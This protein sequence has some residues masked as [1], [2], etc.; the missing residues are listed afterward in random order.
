MKW[1]R[2]KALVPLAVVLA[3]LVGVTLLFADRAVE[4]GVEGAGTHLVGARVDLDAA[5]LHVRD[6]SLA[7]R[8]LAV[9]NP[10]KPM[11]NLFEAAEIQMDLSVFPMLEQKLLLDTVAVRGLRFNTPRATSGAIDRPSE[12]AQVARRSVTEWLGGVKVPPLELSTLTKAVNVAGIS[13]ESLATLREARHAVAY[14]DTAKAKLLADLQ[15]LD[16]RPTIDS[17]QVLAERLKDAN[18]RTLGIG[19]TRQAVSDV[20]RTVAELRRLDDRLRAF[21]SE[22]RTNIGG[23][24]ARLNAIPAA[25]E[26]D[27]AYAKGLLRLPSF[28][29]PSLGPQLFSEVVATQVAEILYWAQMVERYI[30]PGIKRQLEPGPRRMRASG[31][32]V[33]FPRERTHPNFLMRVAEL[34]LAIGGEGAAAG[35]Y[36]ARLTGVTTQPAVYGAPTTF[37]MTRSGG[38]SGPTDARVTGLLD[39]RSAP[40]RDTVAA[41]FSGITLPTIPLSGLGATVAMGVGSSDL[42]FTRTGGRID[43]TWIWRAPN[44]AWTRDSTTRVSSTPALRLVEDALWN[45]MTRL[46]SLE[47]EARFEGELT[48]PSLGIRTNLASA[49][50]NALR[51]Q[52]GEEIRRAE[53]Q[54]RA[55][56]DE[57]VEAKVAAARAEADKVRAEFTDRV[58]AER[59]RLEEQKKA[60]EAKLRELVRIPG[61]G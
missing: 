36:S 10:G 29:L 12:T 19:G 22:T 18:L 56:V 60:L 38:R 17:A 9:T 11:T 20:R 24:G 51:D 48:K 21:E 2:W 28:D 32:T 40:V 8:G 49:V 46:D 6:A 15:A 39:H 4:R 50:A 30:P 37:A 35:E 33:R 55:K 45:A 61:I 47:I 13:A 59:A 16:P 57:L 34:S 42:R 58:N 54:V 3:L 25:R 27:Y 43:G 7:L 53:Q 41:R 23:L 14:V 5:D 1:I 44:V 31:T 26:Q 52:L